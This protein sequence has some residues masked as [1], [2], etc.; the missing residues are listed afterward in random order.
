M[1]HFP[2][3][4]GDAAVGTASV[5]RRKTT[6]HP[7]RPPFLRLGCRDNWDASFGEQDL[8]DRM[9]VLGHTAGLP[10]SRTLLVTYYV[11]LKTNPFVI[12]TGIEGS[13]KTEL[14]TLFATAV[15]GRGSPQ[16]ALINGDTSWLNAT[17]DQHSFRSLL[18]HFTS[19][20]FLELLQEA[21]D[22]G[23]A[24]KAF[25]VCFDG[26]RPAE[27]NYYFA[28]L[29]S[30]DDAGRKRLNLPGVADDERPVVP[31]NVSITATVNTAE[32]A[33]ALSAAVL[34]R[35]GV[36]AFRPTKC[37]APV[38]YSPQPAPVG[39]Q[40]LWLRAS[41]RD[42]A[43]ARAQLVQHIGVTALNRLNCS[44]ALAGMLR[45]AGIPLTQRTR[46][47]LTLYV[48]NSFDEHGQGLFDAEDALRNAQIAF[49]CQVAQRVLW[50]LRDTPD[51]QVRVFLTSY[52]DAL[53]PL[54]W[55]G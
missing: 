28:T 35:A 13:G 51:D 19:L 24:G 27:V 42:E 41:Q 40:R 30:V 37:D 20:R 9:V 18:D 50:R 7:S 49:D 53:P 14:V 34:R 22:P 45:R 48:A 5:G 52:L 17:G 16:Y 12:L 29:L 36:I 26:M 3:P 44:E 21:A 8:I 1:S 31:P 43:A 6:Y 38:P 54:A 33:G 23:S 39:M 55:A 10:F 15:L 11:S 32:Y 25:L 46:Q 47:E 4:T 2:H